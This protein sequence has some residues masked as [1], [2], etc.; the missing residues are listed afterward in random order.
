MIASNV[1][2]TF[3]STFITWLGYVLSLKLFKKFNMF[4][5]N[6]LYSATI[7]LILLMALVKVDYEKYLNGT[8]LFSLLQGTAVVSMAVPLYLH[9]PLLKKYFRKIFVSI[10]VGSMLGMLFVWLFA[11]IFG[12]KAEV[13]ASLIPKSATLPVALSVSE[14]LGGIPSLTVLFVLV[15]ALF[16]L[17]FGPGFLERLNINSKFAKGLT[18][19]ACAQALGVNKSFEWGEEAGAIGSVGMTASA[20]FISLIIPFLSILI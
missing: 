17:I 9:W 8:G 12:L 20:V 4:W 16:S 7:L 3:F 19:G 2:Y 11:K 18:M 1:G 5:L 14:S 10:M 6:P 15:S 13:V